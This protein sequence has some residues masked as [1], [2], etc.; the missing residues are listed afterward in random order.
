MPSS[1]TCRSSSQGR[2]EHHRPPG[3]AP[4]CTHHDGLLAR[5]PAVLRRARDD[6]VVD[7]AEEATMGSATSPALGASESQ[8]LTLDAWR[9]WWLWLVAGIGWV[10]ASLV[11]LQF[12]RASIT[13]VGVIIGCMFVV[14]GMQQIAAAAV[15]QSWRWLWLTFGF[16][17]IAA[18]VLCF[19][20]PE[21]TFAG[22]ADML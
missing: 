13:T 14:T 12:D 10:V 3:G 11:I 16:L 19:I 18:G 6:P 22:F 21:A 15:A 20:N 4:G 2:S 9:F 5:A 8:V 17:F 1:D 7:P